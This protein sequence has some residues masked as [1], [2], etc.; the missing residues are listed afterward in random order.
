M[1]LRTKTISI[2]V[3][4]LLVL[5]LLLYAIAQYLLIDGFRTLEQQ[6]VRDNLDRVR[7]SVSAE[8]E[9]QL[10]K[11]SDWSSWDD[12]YKYM[13]DHNQEF[14]TSNLTDITLKNLKAH[15]MIFLDNS[16]KIVV[17]QQYDATSDK[18]IPLSDNIAKFIFPQ[19][20]FVDIKDQEAGFGGIIML[21]EGPLMLASRPILTSDGKGP[22]R[23]VLMLGSFLDDAAVQRLSELTKLPIQMKLI[24]SA[25]DL[26]E[27]K[28][29]SQNRYAV[30][31]TSQEIVRGFTYFD[32]F[33]GKPALILSVDIQRQIMAQ[34]N[35]T[36]G[37]LINALI[38]VGV[39]FGLIIFITL[40]KSVISRI[41]SLNQEVTAVGQSQNGLARIGPHG[42]DEIG[43]LCNAI[44]K[45]IDT[46]EAKSKTIRDI[47]DNV[48]FGFFLCDRNMTIL[49]GFTKSCLSLFNTDQFNGRKFVDLLNV[50]KAQQEWLETLYDQAFSD[51]FPQEVALAQMPS[52]FK[53]GDRYL[54]I[55]GSG[56]NNAA[57]SLESVLF[58]VTD[59]TD[60]ETTE[61]ENRENRTLVKILKSP[62]A[63]YDF[64]M[65]SKQHLT[66]IKNFI[67]GRNEDAAR[68]PLHTLKGNF[69]CF[70]LLDISN[71]IQAIEETHPI[72]LDE[73]TKIEQEAK[74]FLQKNEQVLGLAW[75][76]SKEPTYHINERDLE[77]LETFAASPALDT[78]SRHD[79]GRIIGEIRKK[80][81]GEII[82]PMEDMV[83]ALAQ[84]FEKEVNFTL[85]GADIKVPVSRV[86]PVIGVL[87]HLLRNSVHHG[88]EQSPYRGNKPPFASVKLSFKELNGSLEIR[89]SDDGAGIDLEA[90][91]Q[92]AIDLKAITPA[93]AEKMSDSEKCAL[94]FVQQ[95]STATDKNDVSGQG[96]GMTA[97]Q[98]TVR[99]LNG[100]IDIATTRGEGT[101]FTIRIPLLESQHDNN[102]ARAA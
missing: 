44:I 45:M 55:E 14:I 26:D 69:A 80:P 22:S 56:I 93:Q 59:I 35:K 64:I 75:D 5:A 79:L 82:G 53:F 76:K 94:I 65:D 66:S 51:T 50:S 25:R 81:I 71:L 58:C 46:I 1:S 85:E 67:L 38:G 34:G 16:G 18:L 28:M 20:P 95:L 19:S 40:E 39:I 17:S 73:V 91:V 31:V 96:V 8:M 12:A 10:T 63:F 23:G 54:R 48:K 27:T 36:I 90:V 49:P 98:Q 29:T 42:S 4:S 72:L 83:K 43:E 2:I 86:K 102:F 3:S 47:V 89:V 11:I 101:C 70:D 21:P 92:R 77:R 62:Q 99:E 33:E 57:G 100:S 13:F 84:R 87:P 24:H 97:V 30:Q 32:D 6:S 68:R 74:N 15:M 60:L 78:G 7:N 37:I 88:I 9:K 61:R 41:I 52:K